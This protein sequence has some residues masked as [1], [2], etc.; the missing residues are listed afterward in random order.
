[1]SEPG[2]QPT[3][4]RARPQLRHARPGDEAA[5]VR[6]LRTR[7][8]AYLAWRFRDAPEPVVQLVLEADG[9]IVGFMAHVGF[10]T[11]V[12]G[13]RVLLGQGGDTTVEKGHQG[14]FGMKQLVHGFLGGEHP[15]ALRM[16][17]PTERAAVLM[18][19][20]GGGSVIGRIPRFARGG[21]GAGIGNPVLRA[22][23]G[24]ASDL[25]SAAVAAPPSRLRAERI[26][27]PG[28]EVDE[29]AD[30]S[31]H[32]ARC[33]RVRDARYLRWRWL[34]PRSGDWEL[35]GV[36]DRRGRLRGWAVIGEDPWAPGFGMVADLLAPD[37]AAL[38]ALLRDAHRQLAA[39]G[40]PRVV[41]PLHDPR[42]WAARAIRSAGF[43]PSGEGT[44]VTCKV[45]DERLGSAPESWSSWYLTSG[46]HE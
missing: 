18:E 6:I 24:R 32:V 14:P 1:M 34:D 37:A 11:W 19:R 7:T 46:D 40:L 41:V 26:D 10:S 4:P 38:R 42:P 9:R 20:F 16:N 27:D 25:A 35:R 13:E 2:Q 12:D 28:V 21:R 43:L 33:I 3:A 22:L 5:L 31:R 45:L 15:Y 17:F 39:R 23:V 36:R 8:L 29:L 30:A 44:R